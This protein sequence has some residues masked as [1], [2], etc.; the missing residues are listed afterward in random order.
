M[1]NYNN[2]DV[3]RVYVWV[4]A[5]IRVRVRV[6]VRARVRI[7]VRV[8]SARRHVVMVY[9]SLTKIWAV[10]L[11]IRNRV[12]VEECSSSPNVFWRAG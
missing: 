8:N 5:R 7:R 2:R 4:R 6:R 1:C 11:H 9:Y 10:N 3:H 12:Q